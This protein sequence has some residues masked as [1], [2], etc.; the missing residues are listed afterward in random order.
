[1]GLTCVQCSVYA[2]V[3][4]LFVLHFP[5]ISVLCS[6]KAVDD[7][8]TSFRVNVRVR[9]KGREGLTCAHG[10]IG[11]W[12]WAFTMPCSGM[13]NLSSWHQDGVIARGKVKVIL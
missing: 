1:M 12:K 9:F 6:G 8:P 13:G 5:Y 10:L 2:L 3:N 7:G 4:G 11:T